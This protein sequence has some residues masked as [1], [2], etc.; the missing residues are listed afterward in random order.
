MKKLLNYRGW[1][2]FSGME[3]KRPLVLYIITFGLSNTDADVRAE[4]SGTLKF[5]KDRRENV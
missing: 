1:T 5:I 4:C 2:C 3:I